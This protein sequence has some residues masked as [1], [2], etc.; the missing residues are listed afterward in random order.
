MGLIL[1]T[2]NLYSYPIN[3][4][5]GFVYIIPLQLQKQNEIQK[6]LLLK[7][8]L[9][10]LNQLSEI[11]NLLIN[12]ESFK[13]SSENIEMNLKLQNLNNL[14]TIEF[15][16][17]FQ[18]VLKGYNNKIMINSGYIREIKNL[19]NDKYKNYLERIYNSNNI[20]NLTLNQN[21]KFIKN[22]IRNNLTNLKMT[23]MTFNNNKNF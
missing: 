15:L 11:I 13:Q 8:Y 12:N 9:Y 5:S 22:N 6:L 20:K 14:Y 18:K 19:Y 21:L 1:L 3:Q 10:D 17:N 7:Q 4:N 23:F 2:L 16:K